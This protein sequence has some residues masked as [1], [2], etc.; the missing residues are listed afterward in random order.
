MINANL[1]IY[2]FLVNIENNCRYVSQF[3]GNFI[4][5]LSFVFRLIPQKWLFNG[6]DFRRTESRKIGCQQDRISF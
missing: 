4:H 5:F 2:L 3:N 1:Y 6:I